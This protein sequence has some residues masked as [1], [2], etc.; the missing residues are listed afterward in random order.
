MVGLRGG[1]PSVGPRAADASRAGPPR[2]AGMAPDDEDERSR[3]LVRDAAVALAEVRSRIPH[4]QQLCAARWCHARAC[5]LYVLLLKIRPKLGDC[6][7]YVCS[8][9]SYSPPCACKLS[10]H[11]C[12]LLKCTSS[13]ILC[14]DELVPRLRCNHDARR[15]VS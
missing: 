3:D 5:T 8:C 14:F 15:A 11:V 2:G 10:A 9:S 4:A 13:C 12:S 1:S 7:C 6:Y